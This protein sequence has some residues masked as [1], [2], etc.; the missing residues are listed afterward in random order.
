M[1]I[2]ET[3]QAFPYHVAGIILFFIIH[4]YSEYPGLIPLA[5][6]VFYFVTMLAVATAFILI[7]FKLTRSYR[8]AGLLTTYILFIYL[9]FGALL[10]FFKYSAW[11]YPL[12]RYSFLL[13]ALFLL[14]LAAYF[15][16]KRSTG[17][18]KKLTLYFNTVCILIVFFDLIE[19][20]FNVSTSRKVQREESFYTAPCSDC[21]QP[22][23]YVVVMDEYWG[24]TSLKTYFNYDN[25]QFEDFLKSRGFFV[26][27][28][29]ASNYM[30][31]SLSMAST[32]DMNYLSWT[33][34]GKQIQAEDY[35]RAEKTI[36]NS[37][38]IRYLTD[39][40]YA[41]ENY[42]IFKIKNQPS[43]F[44]TGLLPSELEL[45]TFKT[46]FNRMNKDLVWHLHQKAAPRFR[47]LAKHFQSNFKEGNQRLLA[48]TEKSLKSK[49][50]KP[51]FIYTH[52][53]MPHYPCLY[54]SA[55]KEVKTNFY[56]PLITKKEIDEAYLQYLVYTNKVVSA[57]VKNIQDKTDKK[58]VIIVMSDH[59][60]RGLNVKMGNASSNNN[61]LSV[62]L[63]SGKYETFYSSISNVNFFRSV[64]NSL[65][66]ENFPRL[67]DSIVH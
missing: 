4:G 12:S 25:S 22:D 38:L 32:F 61:F 20:G 37:N 19:I 46:L 66:N 49:S 24:S 42:S 34:P 48:L 1:R 14:F 33:L 15:A 52:L 63:P 62:Y 16:I 45:I 23:I 30:A 54:D 56:D 11:L 53:M 8:K 51:R 13:P 27:T 35:S 58:A 17:S 44:N 65:F 41:V 29:P 21:Q 3:F 5:N 26:A 47:W 31:T 64:M 6:L 59:G 2:S 50:E 43:K 9:F 67:K 40:N 39:L 60:Y 57:L 10:D 28:V 55:G 18:F 7:F 36:T